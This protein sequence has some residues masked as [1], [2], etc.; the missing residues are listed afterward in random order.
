MGRD[1]QFMENRIRVPIRAKTSKFDKKY[2]LSSP[3]F[4]FFLILQKIIYLNSSVL[5]IILKLN[6]KYNIV[7]LAIIFS[8][9][10]FI[11]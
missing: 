6:E 2:T 10:L 4:P 9:I 3:K 5:W 11:L 1:S 8:F 7:V